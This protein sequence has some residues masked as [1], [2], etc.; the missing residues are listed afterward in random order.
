MNAMTLKNTIAIF[1]L[2]LSL[3]SCNDGDLEI[4]RVDL[5]ESDIASCDNFRET[6]L[7]FKADENEALIL[8]LPTNFLRNRATTDSI[9]SL[10][11]SNSKLYYR[12]F[13]GDVDNNYFCSVITPATPSVENEITASGGIVRA[14]TTA[15]ADGSGFNH[16]IRIHGAVLQNEAGESIIED[17]FYLGTFST[18]PENAN[19][20]IVYSNDNVVSYCNDTL[21]YK[22]GITNEGKGIAIVLDLEKDMLLD[23]VTE[24]DSLRTSDIGTDS[25]VFFHIFSGPVPEGYFCASE[26]PE[27]PEEQAVYEASQGEISIATSENGE[28]NG[29]VHQIN[30]AKM[31]LL[32]NQDRRLIPANTSLGVLTTGG[33][34]DDEDSQ[35]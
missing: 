4:E 31:L 2:S 8:Q 17:E 21:L 28:N 19:L 12:F 27:T 24:E 26:K 10:I 23:Q 33:S 16:G 30:L 1:V 22:T 14:A 6:G 34:T 29:Y 25:R 32:D 3:F 15:K 35:P 20:D 13:D 18:S 5:S 9:E 11:P 7:I